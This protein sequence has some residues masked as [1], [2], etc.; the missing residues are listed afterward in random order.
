MPGIAAGIFRKTAILKNIFLV[1][2]Y[3]DFTILINY[4][5]CN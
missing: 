5:K 3:I 4:N 2:M 1:E